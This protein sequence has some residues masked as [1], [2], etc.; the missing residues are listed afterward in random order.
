MILAQRITQ[1]KSFIPHGTYS[2]FGFE[3]TPFIP[4][5]LSELERRG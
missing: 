2:N 5:V 1:Y 3:K 4:E